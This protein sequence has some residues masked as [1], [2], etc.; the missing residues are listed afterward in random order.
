ME[1]FGYKLSA[2]QGWNEFFEMGPY[3][4]FALSNI[5]LTY[6]GKDTLD[7][8]VKIIKRAK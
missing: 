4:R 1:T 7:D 6:D 3:N 2:L 5:K 8:L